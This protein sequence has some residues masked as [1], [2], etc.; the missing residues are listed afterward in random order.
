MHSELSPAKQ[1]SRTLS[2]STFCIRKLCCFYLFIQSCA[3]TAETL[4]EETLI[5][6]IA[7]TC[8]P[9]DSLFTDFVNSDFV[10][11]FMPDRAPSYGSS[12]LTEVT[13]LARFCCVTTALNAPFI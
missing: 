5:D 8:V 1:F 2:T 7:Q 3:S 11:Y 10:D 6:N 12:V 9:E 4:P 13:G